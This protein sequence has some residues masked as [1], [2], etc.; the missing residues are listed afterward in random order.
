M[1]SKVRLCASSLVTTSLVSPS[2]LLK[3][4]PTMSPFVR[5][6]HRLTD[7]NAG[8]N[9][10]KLGKLPEKTIYKRDPYDSRQEMFK[11][12]HGVVLYDMQDGERKML[13]A[14]VA[15]FKRLDWG[16]WIRPRAGRYKK[17]WKKSRTQLVNNEKHVFVKGY[18]KRRFDRAVTMEIKDIRHIPEDPYKVYNEMTWQHYNSIKTKNM[19][20][21]KKYGPI[22]YEFPHHVAHHRKHRYY[23][24]KKKKVNYEPPGYHKDIH[25]G[26]GVYRPD[27]SRPQDIMPPDYHLEERHESNHAKL[28]DR[29]KWKKIRRMELFTGGPLSLCSKLRLPVAGTKTG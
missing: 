15:R 11:D 7:Q 12:G 18:H 26:C 16:Q 4:L 1:L 21:I 8:S 2:P 9:K 29:K 28:E 6:F 5:Q 27:P 10:N 22:N 23:A 24:D 13:P 17:L 25:D 19:E 3:F 20:L 14:V